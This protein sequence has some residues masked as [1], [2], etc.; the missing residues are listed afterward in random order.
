[1][2]EAG[3]CCGA[4]QEGGASVAV[5]VVVFVAAEAAADLRLRLLFGRETRM[6]NQL[7]FQL[8]IVHYEMS[9]ETATMATGT[10]TAEMRA[11]RRDG[12]TPTSMLTHS[13]TTTTT[14]LH[15]PR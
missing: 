9:W 5:V 12:T 11:L 1:M 6:E 15:P 14:W 10:M 8:I 3:G 7:R 4:R 2:S 13:L